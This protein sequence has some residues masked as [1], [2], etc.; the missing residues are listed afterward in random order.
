MGMR[1]GILPMVF[2]FGSTA[3]ISFLVCSMSP[4][5]S[6]RTSSFSFTSSVAPNSFSGKEPVGKTASL[7]NTDQCTSG[8]PRYSPAR[9]MGSLASTV[10][11]R[12]PSFLSSSR[13]ATLPSLSAAMVWL[14]FAAAARSK[15]TQGDSPFTFAVPSWAT[16]T[17]RP[18]ELDVEV[19]VLA[20]AVLLLINA[21]LELLVLLHV[22]RRELAFVLVLP[23]RRGGGHHPPLRL[24][25]VSTLEEEPAQPARMGPVG[26][27]RLALQVHEEAEDRLVALERMAQEHEADLL[28]SKGRLTLPEAGGAPRSFFSPKQHPQQTYKRKQSIR[29]EGCVFP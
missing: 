18:F 6:L 29:T 13:M 9:P 4:R 12:L 5:S 15:S 16:L 2:L 17:H 7:E 1:C 3:S 20:G 11:R 19:V 21:G 8:L 26:M 24:A 14:F 23:G 10:Q 27:E 22:G 25:A 28:I